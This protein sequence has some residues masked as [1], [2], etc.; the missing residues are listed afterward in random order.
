MM[1]GFALNVTNECLPWFAHVNPCGIEDRGVTSVQS[2][3][4]TALDLGTVREQLV[5]EFHVVFG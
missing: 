3:L 1:L 2:L 4:G 5:S